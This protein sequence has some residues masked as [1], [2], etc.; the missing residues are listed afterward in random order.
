[1]AKKNPL[2]AVVINAY[3]PP[4]QSAITFGDDVCRLKL[5]IPMSGKDGCAENAKALVDFQGKKL[6]V[7]VEVQDEQ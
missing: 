2:R 4:L 6:K 5:D 7:L 1:M 3:I